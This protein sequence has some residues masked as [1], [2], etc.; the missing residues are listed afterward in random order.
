MYLYIVLFPL[1]A[2]VLNFRIKNLKNSFQKKK[3]LKTEI[4][5]LLITFLM[6]LIIIYFIEQKV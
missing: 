4:F 1:V 5:L 2:Y 3:N 6:I